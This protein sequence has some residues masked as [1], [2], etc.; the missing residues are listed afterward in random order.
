MALYL[1]EH[2]PMDSFW[3]HSTTPNHTTSFIGLKR[4]QAIERYLSLDSRQ[5]KPYNKAPWFWKV[6]V[7]VVTLRRQLYEFLIPSSHIA[8]DESTIKFYGR[9]SDKV[10]M[11]HKPAKEGFIIYTCASYGGA[12][13]DFTLFSSQTGTETDSQGI[14]INL[15]TRT[16]RERQRG[17]TGATATEVHLPPIKALVYTLCYRVTF[18]FQPLQ[19]IC[20]TDNLFTDPHLTRALLTINVGICGTIRLNAPGIPPILK[21][22]ATMKRC[23]LA[24]NQVIHRTVDKLVN[25]M[26]WRDGLR[27]HTVTFASTVYLATA[28]ELAKR[29]NRFVMSSPHRSG[30]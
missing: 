29:K 20:F 6:E 9:K 21:Q 14:S 3:S 27:Q 16:T 13:H 7:A 19:F 5:E 17:S 23:P 15:P 22:I 18:D 26:V 12:V 2:T 28:T 10:L 24:N 11:R 8:V 1:S 25:I 30:Y 4:F